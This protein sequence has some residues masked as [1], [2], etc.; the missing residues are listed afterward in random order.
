ME[1]VIHTHPTPARAGAA[2]VAPPP[3]GSGLDVVLVEPDAAWD[4]FVR[5]APASTF[6]HLAGWREVMRDALGHECHYLVARDQEGS[7]RG[8]LPVVRVRSRLFGDHL[9]SMPFLNDGGPLG[10][11]PAQ[12]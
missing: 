4:T 9:L 10:S 8:V 7:W 11:E 12:A 1:S 2:S 5:Q 3:R 6:C